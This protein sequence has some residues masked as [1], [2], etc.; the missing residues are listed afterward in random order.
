[1]SGEICDAGGR[2][3]ADTNDDETQGSIVFTNCATA[4]SEGGTLLIDGSVTYTV[5]T[6]ADSLSAVYN[7]TVTYLGDTQ[8]I[9]MTFACTG[10]S[11]VSPHTLSA[12]KRQLCQT[13]ASR[14][15]GLE[16]P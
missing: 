11:T 6:G 4:E 1:M 3:V 13:A 8:A 7:V 5:N 2:V 14:S 16:I 15:F 10:I 9:N 12:K